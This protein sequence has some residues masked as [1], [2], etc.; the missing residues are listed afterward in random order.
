MYILSNYI[1]KLYKS[2]FKWGFM[3]SCF[4]FSLSSCAHHNVRTKLI[5]TCWR[6]SC[7]VG[8]AVLGALL[9]SGVSGLPPVPGALSTTKTSLLATTAASFSHQ[10]TPRSNLTT[11]FNIHHK[12][13]HLYIKLKW[14]FCCEKAP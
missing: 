7:P 6:G 1:M 5:F 11:Q 12:T 8:A 13:S 10:Q 14:A 3:F 2:Y 9:G 4:N